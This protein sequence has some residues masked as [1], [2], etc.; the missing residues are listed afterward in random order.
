MHQN[1]GFI[2]ITG[3]VGA[4]KTTI[5]R[6]MLDGL[7]ENRF[8]AAQLVSTQIDAEDT[9]R[10]V[11]AAFGIR[12]KDVEKADVLM[13]LEA[14]LISM[15]GKG[16]RCLLIVDEAQNLTSRAVEELRMLSNFQY[17]NHALLQSF[18][19]GQP[20][21]RNILQSPQMT[22]F[23]QRVIASSHIGPMDV[24]ETRGYVEHRLKCAGAH[25]FPTFTPDSFDAIFKATSG[26]PRRI[27]SLCDRLLLSGFLN[28]KKEF[29]VGDVDLVAD[30]IFEETQ[31]RS[32]AQSHRADG[33]AIESEPKSASN[34]RDMAAQLPKT[35]ER[36]RQSMTSPLDLGGN[37]RAEFSALLEGLN[38]W[39]FNERL[40]RLEQSLRQLEV[41]NGTTL[42]LLQRIVSSMA[43][44]DAAKAKSPEPSSVAQEAAPFS[45]DPEGEVH[46]FKQTATASEDGHRAV[47]PLTA[48]P[49]AELAGNVPSVVTPAALARTKR[50]KQRFRR[51]IVPTTTQVGDFHDTERS[52]NA[53]E[54][55][56]PPRE[57]E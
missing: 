1:E 54:D 3:E 34:E 19:I 22:Q 26:I 8:L 18:L 29:D 51:K 37:S 7:D 49:E 33:R 28:D 4:G 36:Y 46:D 48:A 55:T 25:G 17:G 32:S 13:S 47:E 5:V 12:T 39:Q 21:F 30:E 43:P 11:G 27:N 38:A 24:E 53:P 45:S 40:A 41:I 42:S 52:A 44:D 16:K 23:R 2:V 14:Y 20:E 15:T 57:P 9:L 31:G 35:T 50:S 10:L 6:H 56:A